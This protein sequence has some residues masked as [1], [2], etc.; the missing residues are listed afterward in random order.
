LKSINTSTT[1]VSHG[2]LLASFVSLLG[3]L[4]AQAEAGISAP[5]AVP[6]TMLNS[7]NNIA[8]P[9]GNFLAQ[10][11]PPVTGGADLQPIDL[12]PVRLPERGRAFG[13]L[14]NFRTG[15]LYYLPAKMFVNINVENSL[16]LETN[17]FQTQ[18][19]PSTT[20]VYRIVPDVTIGYAPNRTTRVSANYF[21]FNDT[22]IT[23][24]ASLDRTVQ[25]VGFTGAKDF[26]LN[27]L[28]VLTTSVMAREL[29][30]TKSK[31]L[32]DILPSISLVRRVGTYGA[33]YSSV[34]GQIRWQDIIGSKFMEGD[35]FYSVG[36]V[37]RRPRWSVLADTTL[38]DNFGKG[39]LRGGPNSNHLIVMTMEAN[40]RLSSRVPLVAFVRAQPIFNMGQE[41]RQ[42]FAGFNFRLFGGLR[43][44]LSKPAIFPVKLRAT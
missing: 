25:S 2:L 41:K 8:T 9:T 18:K 28:T 11:A 1:I 6:S 36:A 22:Y 7:A 32:S 20:G 26:Y 27:P 13:T 5:T 29:F 4:A 16:R 35:Q 40:R 30:I 37:Y 21:M 33:V 23:H 10:T 12:T 3:P 14:Q 31:N 34:L 42:G 17:V 43:L 44:E 38:I 19:H 39:N 15:A 24:A